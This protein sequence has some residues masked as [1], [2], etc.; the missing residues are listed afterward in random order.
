[1]S[2]ILLYIGKCLV[3]SKLLSVIR[4]NAFVRRFLLSFLF[5][6][7]RSGERSHTPHDSHSI[8]LNLLFECVSQCCQNT[9]DSFSELKLD[10][11]VVIE[12]M[13]SPLRLKCSP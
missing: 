6:Q 12:M 9:E 2:I 4:K 3:D 11:G 8:E 13:F 10:V 7:R 5:Q 1:M